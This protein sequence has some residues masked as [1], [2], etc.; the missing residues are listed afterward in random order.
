MPDETQ[1]HF[2]PDLA[3]PQTLVWRNRQV[4]YRS[5]IAASLFILIFL[6]LSLLPPAGVQQSWR[7]AGVLLTVFLTALIYWRHAVYDFFCDP[8]LAICDPQGLTL[9]GYYGK[10]SH[11]WRWD[12]LEQVTISYDATPFEELLESSHAIL[13]I[14]L[15][16]TGDGYLPPLKLHVD[17]LDGTSELNALAIAA[18]RYIDGETPVPVTLPTDWQ[19]DWY[20]YP[21]LVQRGN[22]NHFWLLLP[23]LLLLKMT[24][25]AGKH[26][27]AAT[28]DDIVFYIPLWCLTATAT[29]AVCLNI[30]HNFFRRTQPLARA[31]C[32]GLH[33]ALRRTPIRGMP[34]L[35]TG[36][37]NTHIPWQEMRKCVKHLSPNL[38]WG[39]NYTQHI[40]LISRD[41]QHRII[42]TEASAK[43]MRRPKIS[44]S[45]SAPSLTAPC[46]PL[47]HPTRRCASAPSPGTSSPRIPATP[48]RSAAVFC[49]YGRSASPP[50][51]TSS[52]SPY[53]GSGRQNLAPRHRM[54][55]R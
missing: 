19:R 23:Q 1:S 8:P 34:L 10:I 3:N 31:D 7:T 24:I 49:P 28:A 47:P 25:A 38:S 36:P 17:G 50:L 11:Q 51:P 2:A 44:A 40:G 48:S 20:K 33:L 16:N 45:P 39:G 4:D 42:I 5:G 54:P 26:L 46:H 9:Y 12:A 53:P 30:R 27:H 6:W 37:L 14:T 55:C 29:I 21:D 52:S 15:R 43:T 32:H 22:L 41:G 13:C 18:Q 35:F